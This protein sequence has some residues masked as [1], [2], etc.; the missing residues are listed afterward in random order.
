M[1][2]LCVTLLLLP[3]AASLSLSAPRLSVCHLSPFVAF[4]VVLV[5]MLVL[6][7]NSRG[8]HQASK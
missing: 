7:W 3:L 8:T 1:A 5:E 2:R 4:L 6:A